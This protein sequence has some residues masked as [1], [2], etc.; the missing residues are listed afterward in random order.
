MPDCNASYAAA[1]S[2]QYK[3]HA[4]LRLRMQYCKERYL[5]TTVGVQSRG[6]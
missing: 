2:A 1:E 6:E 4:V 3:F 5:V